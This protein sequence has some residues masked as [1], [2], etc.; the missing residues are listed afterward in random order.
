MS[1]VPDALFYACCACSAQVIRDYKTGESLCYAFIE[2]ENKE[3]CEE[4]T[5]RDYAYT[6]P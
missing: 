3:D 5:L 6:F 2:F 4:G 1:T